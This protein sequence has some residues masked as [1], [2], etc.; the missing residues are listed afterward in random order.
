MEP[1]LTM[2]QLTLCSEVSLWLVHWQ[3]GHLY[4]PEPVWLTDAW[5]LLTGRGRRSCVCLCVYI[6]ILYY[7]SR[8]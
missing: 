6:Y 7:I 4:S 3:I 2:V 8:K 5:R 1:L